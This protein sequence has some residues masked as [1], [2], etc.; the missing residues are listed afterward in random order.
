MDE[1]DSGELPSAAESHGLKGSKIGYHP[2]AG[3]HAATNKEQH[4][5]LWRRNPRHH[6]DHLGHHLLRQARLTRSLSRRRRLAI[7][8]IT[9]PV[10]FIGAWIA[11]GAITNRTYSPIDDAISRLAA[12]GADTR[13]VMTLGFIGFGVSLPMFAVAVRHHVS[14]PA[15]FAAAATGLATLA[16]AATPLDRSDAVDMWHGVAATI[17]YVTLAATPMLAA[18]PLLRRGHRA[19]GITAIAAAT[20]SA[21]SLAL[22]T[23]SLPT[24]LFQRLGLTVSDLWVVALALAI[25]TGR[26]TGS[27]RPATES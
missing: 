6:S 25:S 18:R 11:G 17:G 2:V 16:V 21:M 5:V 26:V 19:L 20:V 13:L 7:A 27:T 3:N 4:H 22:T 8:G 12:V 23:T 1:R 14:A 24:G 15:S 9:G 10:A